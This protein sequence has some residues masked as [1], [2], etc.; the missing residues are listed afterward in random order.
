MRI[1]NSFPVAF[2][3]L[4]ALGA[5]AFAQSGPATAPAST[6]P[7]NARSKE[8]K[9][10]AESTAQLAGQPAQL[11]VINLEFKPHDPIPGA[12]GSSA[13]VSPIVCSPDGV[14]FVSFIDTKSFGPQAIDSLDPKGGHEFSLKAIPGL[15]DVN[16][17][18]G[19]FV[20]DSG[21]G[22][23]V[24]GTKDDKKAPDPVPMG[25]GMPPRA[26]YTGERHDYLVEFDSSGNY[27]KAIELPG[28]YQFRRLAA[29]ADDSLLAL[30][31]DRANSIPRLLLMD[32]GGQIIRNLQI[33]AKM[34]ESP[35]FAS[36]Q[37]GG[38]I[39]QVQ[40]ESSL[41]WWIFALARKKILLYQA[42]SNSPV[43]E[44]GAGG[45]VREVPVQFP[46][47]YTLD[48]IIS[49]NDRWIMRFRKNSL[50][51]S[52]EIDTRPEANNYVLYEVEPSDGSLK[53]RIVAETGPIYSIA[54][55]QDGV[56][57]AFSFDGE[58][59]RLQTADIGR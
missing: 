37:A 6:A 40:A 3:G 11:P 12:H 2:L 25:S 1:A 24:R 30:A 31:F 22:V 26:V 55:E 52:G 18:H 45:V 54:C 29:L 20:T 16:S 21:V 10:T 32:S 48:G 39:E 44:V 34:Q 14:P 9:P 42:H 38:I 57:T 7:A 43:L 36:A 5:F 59:I 27:Q 33:P 28:A 41:S 15:Y 23:L 58:K 35:E 4:A 56:L 13:F 50:S 51:G 49:A 46:K 47:G 53:R 17:I 19:Y 8:G